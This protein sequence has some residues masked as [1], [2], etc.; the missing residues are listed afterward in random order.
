MKT[1]ESIIGVASEREE[2]LRILFEVV[3]VLGIAVA[4]SGN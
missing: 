4:R 3:I 1:P 2:Y